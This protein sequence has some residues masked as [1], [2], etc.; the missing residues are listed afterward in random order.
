MKIKENGRSMIEM[1]GVLAIVAVLSIGGLAGFNNAMKKHKTNKLISDFEMMI[2]GLSEHK[3]EFIR[4]AENTSLKNHI[5]K[6]NL[7]PKS[8]RSND[9]YIYDEINNMVNVY[10]RNSRITVD[11]YIKQTSAQFCSDFVM[12]FAKPNSHALHHIRVWRSGGNDEIG[13]YYGDKV[14]Q[15]SQKCINNMTA[16]DVYQMCNSCIEGNAC[17]L[18]FEFLEY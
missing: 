5:V 3:E 8:W 9:A 13:T 14:C 12:G 4:Y 1:L 17:I 2:E 6:F 7:L 15:A 11:Y 18:V 16:T 10:M